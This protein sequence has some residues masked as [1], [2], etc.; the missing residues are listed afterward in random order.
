M[1]I[2]SA[3]CLLL[4]LGSVST[5]AAAEEFR[6]ESRTFTVPDGLV[7]ELVA[8]S[9][10]VDR[11]IVAA[12][13]Q[14]G[15]LYVADSSGSNEKPSIQLEKRPHKIIR[16]E[17][18]DGDGKYD[19]RTVF[20]DR[21]MFPSGA[22][23]LDGSLYVSAPPSIWKLTDTD[24]DGVAD[25]RVEWFKGKTLT[26]CANDL[27]GPYR[28]PDGWIYWTKGAFAEQTY[29]R[30][31]KPPFVTKAAHIFR[32]RPDGSGIEPVM[33]G[34][35][36]NPVD[37]VI[38]NEG[39]RLFT[40]TF[41][42]H[43]EGGKRDGIIHAVYGG[44]YGKIHEVIDGHPRTRPEMMPTLVQLGAAA[45]CG[46]LRYESS[47][48]GAKYR[49]NLFACQFNLRKV[50]RHVLKPEGATFKTEDSDFL[51]SPDQDFHPT[52]VI[53]DLDG[54]ILVLD[55]GGWYKLC[56]PTS[57][58]GKPDV[59]GGIYRIRPKW[60]ASSLVARSNLAALEKESPETLI[61]RLGST[62]SAIQKRAADLLAKRGP[63]VIRLLDGVDSAQSVW[64]ACRIDG[65]EARAY[66]RKALQSK[67]ESVAQT[68]CQAAGLHRDRDALSSLTALLGPDRSPTVR[69]AA[70][71]A[72]GRTGDRRQVGALI[73]AIASTND[74]A[75][76]HSLTYALIEIGDA[77]AIR[78]ALA[79]RDPKVRRAAL[80]ALDQLGG[81]QTAAETVARE[82]KATDPLLREAAV[83]IVGRHPEWGEALA[84][85]L[86]VRLAAKEQSQVEQNE[87]VIQLSKFS[88]S[89]KV[90]ALIA[91][92]AVDGGTRQSR[93]IALCAMVQEPPK[94]VPVEWSRALIPALQ[95]PDA[96]V[97]ITAIATARAWPPLIGKEAEAVA[98][99]LLVIGEDDHRPSTERLA[100]LHAIASG[101]PAP[102]PKLVAF[103]LE[104]LNDDR[105]VSERLDAADILAR[106][107]LDKAGLL[108]V[109]EAIKSSGP[110]EVDKLLNAF[111]TCKDETIGRALIQALGQSKAKSG[112][113]PETLRPRLAKFGPEV[114]A[115]AEPFLESLNVD[116]GKQ[117]AR[118]DA[119]LAGLSVGDPRRGQVVFNGNKAACR[120][121]HSSGYVGG[122]VGPDLTNI[123]AIRTDRDLLESIVFPSLSFVRSFEPVVIETKE[124]KVFGGV[125]KKDAADEVVL[126]TS[127]N[128]EVRIPRTTIEQ[129]RSGNV[130][131]MP[132]GLDQQLTNQDL[133]DL[134]A[135]LKAGR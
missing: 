124:G 13:D 120:T 82:L 118:L 95:S 58:L 87:L 106:A 72:I 2:R 94:P 93:L 61:E 105:T 34:G 107:K 73:E 20:A 125:I 28:G 129:M 122:K 52:D 45:P 39:E 56:C 43:P 68:A 62:D 32:A 37:V 64:L 57:Q 7:V 10:L 71:E 126:A 49:D 108:K 17:D 35:M 123:G 54:S 55:T 104:Q 119:M 88:N 109:V 86:D 16:L 36:D 18:V 135:F 100:A 132:A 112:L 6:L 115:A 84:K 5:T 1:S 23:W 40:T 110:L 113:R 69:R 97:S 81:T 27:H 131:L 47:T 111:E 12:I 127:A 90:K 3:A 91:K 63:S 78:P 33:T 8:S 46:L 50:S 31:G 102:S 130:S 76:E 42:Q 83:W 74:R 51:V 65:A 48:L 41:L 117:K 85:S 9:P 101:V 4:V 11:P 80:I 133:A 53:E 128:E 30:T 66:V 70:A 96:A 22:M 75:L 116:A 134:I 14:K 99:A 89:E 103:L 77:E 26:G 21:M 121:C 15:R 59:L 60:Q 67:S 114:V 38:T 24:G 25:V 79:R 98:S 92:Y 19:R 29:P 44:V